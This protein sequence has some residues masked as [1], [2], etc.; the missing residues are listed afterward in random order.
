MIAP[1]RDDVRLALDALGGAIERA[2]DAG[3]GV[4]EMIGL[5]IAVRALAGMLPSE[6]ASDD[7]LEVDDE[8]CPF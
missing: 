1:T 5:G 6:E 7:N 3:A 8:L 4:S 2:G